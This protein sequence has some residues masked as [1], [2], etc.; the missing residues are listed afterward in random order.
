MAKYV[1]QL[2]GDHGALDPKAW[3]LI[4]AESPQ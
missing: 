3:N 4:S 1:A 2:T